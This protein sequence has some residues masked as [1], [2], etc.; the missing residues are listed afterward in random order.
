M[1]TKGGKGSGVFKGFED[2]TDSDE[3][4]ESGE[5]KQA[6]ED[7]AQLLDASLKKKTKKLSVGD[8]IRGEILVLG[9]EDVFVS[10]GAQSDGVASRRELVDADGNVPYKV[11]DTLE[12][13]VTHVKG[14]DIR[15][16]PNPTSK[17]LAE[18]LEDAFDMMMPIEGKVAEI[19]K[20]GFRVLIKGKLAFCPISQL[21][22]K[23]IEGNGEE[24]IGKKFDFRI[25]KFEE[26]GRN[27]VVSR[28]KIL[29]EERDLSVGS[30]ATE[31]KAGEVVRGKVSRL[32]PF[33]AFIELAPGIDGLAH[34]SE[35]SWSRV[36]HPSEA[37]QVGQELAVKI[38]KMESME[39]PKGSR[40]RVSLSVKQ[41]GAEPWQN[42]SGEV[43][44][45]QL[46]EG[47][48]TRC[49]QF[50]AFVEISP[51]VEGLIPLSEMSYTKRVMRSDEIVKEGDRVSVMVKDVNP[52]TRRISLSLKDAGT[53]PWSLVAHKF[54]VGSIVTGK[55]ERR[56]P[57]GLF[58]KIDEGVTGLLPKS[59]AN[60]NPEFP[61]EKLKVGEDAVVQIAE[62]RRE[63]RRISLQPPKDPNADD[64]K[65]FVATGD[66]A[67][68]ST[69]FGTL[70]DKLK[71]AMGSGEKKKK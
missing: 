59:K 1:T 47:K 44:A 39:G 35:L 23:H 67:A 16:S 25:T 52:E 69:G 36:G 5:S 66:A 11:G 56:E 19:V 21:D 48:V 13:Y 28:R 61:F 27:I 37:V 54:P 26:G 4:L 12:L 70:A 2:F 22:S 18:G 60:E 38:L 55:V 62:L 41:A 51:G 49:A 31:H 24:Y 32:E 45:G 58:I 53:D 42:L 64:W 6:G 40:L 10:T 8:K 14:T 46:V 57:Y 30:F 34:V 17:N 43:R 29:D 3:S 71:A 68:A 65:G 9:K 7:F 63:E 33:G 50:G 20:G 15:L